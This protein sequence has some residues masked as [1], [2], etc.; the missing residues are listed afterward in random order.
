MYHTIVYKS[1]TNPY[2][3][4]VR[5]GDGKIWNNTSKKF[6]AAPAWANTAISLTKN[7]YI[8]GIPVTLPDMTGGDYHMLIYD[9]SSP[10]D[11]DVVKLGKAIKWSGTD[12]VG[13]LLDV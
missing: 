1:L 3:R 13:S 11:T 10:A 8:G 4:I 9:N 12:L 5:V 2:L 6:E 7:A